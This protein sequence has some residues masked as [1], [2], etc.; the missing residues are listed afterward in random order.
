MRI[1]VIGTSHVAVL[2]LGW[3]VVAPQHPDLVM[4]FLAAPLGK[5]ASLKPEAGRLASA[6]AGTRALLMASAGI[7]EVIPE[8]F[9]AVLLA[10][11]RLYLP[12]LDLRMSAALR[13][14]MLQDGMTGTALTL[15]RR[16][17]RL[18]PLPIWFAHEPLWADLPRYR[19]GEGHLFG[20]AEVLGQMQARIPLRRARLLPQP[21]QTVTAALLT[22]LQ[23]SVETEPLAVVEA[24]G[25]AFD[26]VHMNA[27]FGAAWWAANLPV[28]REFGAV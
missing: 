3:E 10:G 28:I 24:S 19:R 16:I 20:Y 8:N 18:A 27:E 17:R 11:M 13:E 14:A 2:K 21:P 6:D 22:H 9:D 5:L 7:V 1:C 23:Y 4:T 15:A 25:R 12:R 26:Q